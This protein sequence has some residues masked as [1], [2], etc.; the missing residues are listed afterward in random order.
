MAD[1][2]ELLQTLMQNQCVN[3]GSLASGHEER[4]V[5]TLSDFLTGAVTFSPEPGR[6]SAVYRVKGY[7]PSAPALMLMGHT[8]VVPVTEAGWS[9]DPFAGSI[10]DGSVWGRGAVDMLNM[11]AAMAVVFQ[12]WQAQELPQLPGDL[13]LFAVADEEAGG[14]LGASPFLTAHPTALACDYMLTE[15]AYPDLSLGGKSTHLVNVAEKGVNWRTARSKGTPGHA[16]TP[17]GR[18]SALLPIGRTI[19]GLNETPS[20]VAIG[21]EWAAFVASL[22]LAD[23]LRTQLLD[24]D[25]IDHAIDKIA[26]TD[27]GLA[28]YI[29]A[30]THMAVATTVVS[31]GTKANTIADEAALQID[32]RMLP[33]QSGADVDDHFRKALGSVVDE[34]EIEVMSYQLA[35]SS[36]AEGLLWESLGDAY[37]ELTGERAMAPAMTPAATDARFFRDRG[38]VCYGAGLFDDAVSFSDFLDMFHGNDERISVQSLHDTVAFLTQTVEAFGARSRR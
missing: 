31:G 20:P 9:A 14:N 2:V 7:D 33:G 5:A 17:Y 11:T 32:V 3:D 30:C 19:V 28:R 4:S 26:M 38:V 18:S 1:V 22:E 25:L 37:Q 12:K 13:V 35:S 8:D 24:P 21:K 6:T 36:P 15:I 16:S 34:L 10:V 23:S 29:D 27:P